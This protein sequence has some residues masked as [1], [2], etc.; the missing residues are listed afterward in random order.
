MKHHEIKTLLLAIYKKE[1]DINNYISLYDTDK[2]EFIY[3]AFFEYKTDTQHDAHLIVEGT[4]TKDAEPITNHNPLNDGR[5][6]E[7]QGGGVFIESWTIDKIAVELDGIEIEMINL[8]DLGAAKSL[9][10]A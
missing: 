5:I 10:S 4:I 2:Q 1:F 3:T 6:G 7:K 9:E 8:D